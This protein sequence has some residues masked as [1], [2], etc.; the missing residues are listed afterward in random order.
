VTTDVQL[1][2]TDLDGTLWERDSVVHERTRAAMAV[3]AGAGMPMLVATGRRVASTRAPLSVIGLAPPAVVLNGALGLDL[4]SGDRFHRSSFLSGDAVA[5]LEAFVEH[6]TE[7]CVYIDHDDHPVWV[8]PRPDTH[9]DHLASFGTDVRVGEL[10]RI[11]ATEHVLGF[12]VIGLP[13]GR[14]EPLA[15]QLRSL[16][17]PHVDRDRH[18]GGYGL[19][20]APPS[21]SKWDGVLAYC[22]RHDLDPGAVLAIGDGPNDVELLGN[23]AVAVAPS[24]AHPAARSLARHIVGRAVDGGWAEL[25]DI[26][27]IQAGGAG[28]AVPPR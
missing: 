5:V 24:D 27:G 12:S 7:P 8:G 14:A 21:Q 22:Q 28:R 18:Y 10:R 2:V 13:T 19:T 23:A 6:G 16:A 26:L 15:A 25:L 11:V 1:V 20:V 9:P 17:T 4:A 3:L